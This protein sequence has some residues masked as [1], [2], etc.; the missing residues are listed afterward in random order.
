[1][2]SY[3]KYYSLFKT[4][5]KIVICVVII[6]MILY[7]A[8]IF[9][10]NVRIKK[11]EDATEAIDAYRKQINKKIIALELKLTQLESIIRNSPN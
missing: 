3:N 9:S 10:E 6:I 5:Y 4:H 1:M 11:L 7:L 8:Y 2:D